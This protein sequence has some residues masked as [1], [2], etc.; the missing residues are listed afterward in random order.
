MLLQMIVVVYTVLKITVWSSILKYNASEC[1]T[2]SE[3]MWITAHCQISLSVIKIF[4][5]TIWHTTMFFKIVRDFTERIIWV[6]FYCDSI[7]RSCEWKLT[8]YL[9]KRKKIS[10]VHWDHKWS[11]KMVILGELL[12]CPVTCTKQERELEFGYWINGD[13]FHLHSVNILLCVV[14]L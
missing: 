9:T 10:T 4:W 6:L 13:L 1:N 5:H 11:W 12:R 8:I 2:C 3:T 14:N 7:H